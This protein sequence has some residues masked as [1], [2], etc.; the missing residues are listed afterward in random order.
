MAKNVIAV[1]K[2]RQYGIA[3]VLGEIRDERAF[4]SLLAALEDENAFVSSEAAMALGGLGK[5]EAV[6]PLVR[7]AGQGD[8]FLVSFAAVQAL[9][10]IG[11]PRAV[12]PLRRIADSTQATEEIQKACR[13]A[14]H[15][16]QDA[17]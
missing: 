16:L 9:G 11:D 7:A 3:K 12:E 4:D 15:K 5:Q 14:I 13:E 10:E 6:E 8:S 2:N 17:P 1:G